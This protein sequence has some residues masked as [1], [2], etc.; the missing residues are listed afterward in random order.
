MKIIPE[1]RHYWHK[2]WSIRFGSIALALQ[3]LFLAWGNLPLELWGMMPIEVKRVL[4]DHIAFAL[5]AIFFGLSM[6]SRFVKQPKV[7]AIRNG[8]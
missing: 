5:P 3:G 7:E 1:I 4:P 6:I 8:N 2:L